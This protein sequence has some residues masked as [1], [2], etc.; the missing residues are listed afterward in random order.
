DETEG[1]RADGL[2]AELVAG[3]IG[4]HGRPAVGEVREEARRGALKGEPDR[5]WVR[6]L[7]RVDDGVVRGVRTP[8]LLTHALQ[9]VL[10]IRRGER[11][12]IMEGDAR[13][14]RE[15]VDEAVGR[16]VPLSGEAGHN[17]APGI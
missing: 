4:H 5:H 8:A 16:D 17:L 15:G 6:R 9:A 13:A 2:L 1:T 12:A 10:H 7:D 11:L 3:V 14:E